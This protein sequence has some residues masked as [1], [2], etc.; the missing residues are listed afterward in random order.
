MFDIGIPE[1]LLL[2]VVTLIFVGPK[3]LPEAVRTLAYWIGRLKRGLAEVRQEIEAEL[4]TDE[5][6]QDLHNANVMQDLRLAQQDLQNSIDD[7]ASTMKD[8][9]TSMQDTGSPSGGTAD[10]PPVTKAADKS[11][12][13]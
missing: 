8:G 10:L 1:L 2:S 5:I 3:Q 9:L 4:G 7:S 11:A 6:R 12:E 13:V